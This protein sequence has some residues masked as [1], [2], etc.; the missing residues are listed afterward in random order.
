MW[1]RQK[2][3]NVLRRYT[4]RLNDICNAIVS[5]GTPDDISKTH[6]ESVRSRPESAVSNKFDT[7][8]EMEPKA[9]SQTPVAFIN[10]S[11]GSSEERR[12]N[13]HLAR[14]HVSKFVRRGRQDS[15]SARVVADSRP[16]RPAP[17]T[18]ISK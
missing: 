12:L 9:G 7:K 10:A 15:S 11:T 5:A 13:K 14:K 6:R 4:A 18:D 8:P 3:R 1:V 16:L 2:L 17:N